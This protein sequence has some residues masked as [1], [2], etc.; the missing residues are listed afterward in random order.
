M[1]LEKFDI[2]IVGA[3]AVGLCCAYYLAEAGL[4]NIVIMEKEKMPAMGASGLNA[5]GIRT[6]FSI[7]TNIKFSL[8]T[9]EIYENFKELFDQ[10]INYREYGYLFLI[11]NDEELE[12]FKHSVSLQKSLG[13]PVEIINVEDIKK[14][15][16]YLFLDDIICGSF[17]RR[18]GYADP[19]S[20]CM[21][22]MK[23]AKRKGVEVRLKTEVIGMEVN[24]DKIT[25]IITNNGT[26]KT[27][28]V[29]NAAGAYAG[30]IGKMVGIDLPVEPYRR[31]IFVTYPVPEIKED[32]PLVLHLKSGF[33]FRKELD[34]VLMG[35]TD[36]DEKP[37]FKTDVNPEH[38]ENVIEHAIYRV[39]LLEKTGIMKAWTGLYACTPDHQ[40]IIGTVPGVKGFICVC[41]FSGHGMQHAPPSGKVVSEIITDGKCHSFDITP[42]DYSRFREAKVETE[43]KRYLTFI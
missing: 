9:L 41:G 40:P 39:P 15:L 4:R 1:P 38:M 17:S 3:G 36:P 23:A 25:G 34:S 7:T 22:Y 32:C 30:I 43:I 11:S 12:V 33:Y 27:E 35:R 20:I 10:E 31:H 6:Q 14:T 42:F 5:G 19:Y 8:F 24:N 13:A 2:V 18:S 16:P 28:Y 26:V 21:G 37:G 29:V